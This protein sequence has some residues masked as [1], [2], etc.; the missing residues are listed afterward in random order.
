MTLWRRLRLSLLLILA[1]TPAAVGQRPDLRPELAISGA[2]KGFS[3]SP[4]GVL[5]FTTFIHEVH[6]SDDAGRTWPR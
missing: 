3:L 6:R 5:W 4:D 1:L 2:V